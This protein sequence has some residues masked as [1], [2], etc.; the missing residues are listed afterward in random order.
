MNE[1]VKT[2]V[3]TLGAIVAEVP[4]VDNEPRLRSYSG[5]GMYGGSCVSVTVDYFAEIAMLLYYIGRND[6]FGAFESYVDSAQVDDMG[7]GEVIY[8]LAAKLDDGD[9]LPGDDPA[10]VEEEDDDE[11]ED[12][13]GE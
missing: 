10:E 13:G 3:N 4:Y 6:E 12:G 7:R 2:F 8:F 1:D 5:R 9:R 11:D